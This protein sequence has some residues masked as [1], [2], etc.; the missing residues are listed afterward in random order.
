M[1]NRYSDVVHEFKNM[2]MFKAG[3]ARKTHKLPYRY[4]GTGGVVYGPYIVQVDQTSQ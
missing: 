3:V 1:G 4:H 2:D